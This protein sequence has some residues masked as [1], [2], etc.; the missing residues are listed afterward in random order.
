MKMKKVQQESNNQ[1]EAIMPR[2]LKKSL[3]H[4]KK[5]NKKKRII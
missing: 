5:T 4:I 2:R 3:T 1:T